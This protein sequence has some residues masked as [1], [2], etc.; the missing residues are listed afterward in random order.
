[1][2]NVEEGFSRKDDQPSDRWFE[3]MRTDD[4]KELHMMDYFKNKI[5]SREDVN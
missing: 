3:P 2:I 1:M 4:G 5:L